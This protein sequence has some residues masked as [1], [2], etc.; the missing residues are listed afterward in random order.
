[1]HNPRDALLIGLNLIQGPMDQYG[2]AAPEQILD[3]VF[4]RRS[5]MTQDEFGDKFGGVGKI[6]SLSFQ[7]YMA[8]PDPT[9]YASWAS[10]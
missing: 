1:V 8:R 7:R 2:G 10:V 6:F 9:P 3:P 5:R 4:F